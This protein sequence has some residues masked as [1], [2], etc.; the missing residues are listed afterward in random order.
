MRY[1]QGMHEEGLALAHPGHLERRMRVFVRVGGLIA[2]ALV[3]WMR[4]REE[5]Y[6]ERLNR[7]LRERTTCS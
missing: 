5:A 6:S 2:P 1:L 7:A 3:R 4:E